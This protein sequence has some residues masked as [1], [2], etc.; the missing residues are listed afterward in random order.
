MNKLNEDRNKEAKHFNGWGQ[1]VESKDE[2]CYKGKQREK[3]KQFD[4]KEDFKINS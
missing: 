3:D 1:I 2:C 4:L